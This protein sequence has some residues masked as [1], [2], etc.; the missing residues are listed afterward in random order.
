MTDNRWIWLD[1]DGTFADLYAVDGWLDDLIAHN[2]RPY[3]EA[4]P[5]YDMY[6][7]ITILLGL[8]IIGY[9]IGIVS[10]LSKDHNQEYEKAVTATKIEWLTRYGMDKILDEILITSYG[11]NKS[12]TCEKYGFGILVDDEEQNRKEWNNGFT[13]NAQKNILKE[14]TKLLV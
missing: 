2:V 4:K 8:K 6:D 11:V 13:I 1:M 14:L 12:I 5:M 10:W 3:R 7:F 9:K